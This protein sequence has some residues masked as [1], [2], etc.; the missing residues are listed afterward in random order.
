[1][2]QRGKHKDRMY[3]R[4]PQISIHRSQFWNHTMQWIWWWVH[5]FWK[6]Y[7]FPAKC[8]SCDT[9][10]EMLHVEHESSHTVCRPRKPSVACVNFWDLAALWNLC[11]G[12]DVLQQASSACMMQPASVGLVPFILNVDRKQVWDKSDWHRSHVVCMYVEIF[13]SI[14]ISASL[15]QWSTRC[16]FQHSTWATLNLD[17]LMLLK[18]SSWF[19]QSCLVYCLTSRVWNLAMQQPSWFEIQGIMEL[20][21]LQ[22]EG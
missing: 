22:K 10:H 7:H 12:W 14:R 1:M 20:P 2:C 18:A 4:S 16:D 17:L 13:P 8:I 6:L 19:G 5:W 3:K 9:S 11:T 15:I 21:V